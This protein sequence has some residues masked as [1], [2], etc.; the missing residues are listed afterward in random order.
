M[1]KRDNFFERMANTEFESVLTEVKGQ[2]SE[3][4]I[5]LAIDWVTMLLLPLCTW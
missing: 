3:M 5:E 2:R 1:R 4:Q